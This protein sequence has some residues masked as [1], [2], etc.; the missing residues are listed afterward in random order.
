MIKYILLTLLLLQNAYSIELPKGVI[1]FNENEILYT[2][3]KKPYP[4]VM[5][6]ILEGDPLKEGLYTFR[7]KVPANKNI[8]LHVHFKDERVSVLKGE[9]CIGFDTKEVTCIQEGGYYVNPKEVPHYLYTKDS[10]T[11]LQVTGE[12][13]WQM[14]VLPQN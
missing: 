2:K 7:I 14:H 3:A 11:I 9:I 4:P 12:G 10:E 8:P 5:M 13:A 6:A 1:Q